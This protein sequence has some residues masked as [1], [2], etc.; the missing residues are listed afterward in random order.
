MLIRDSHSLTQEEERERS[1]ERQRDDNRRIVVCVV[2]ERGRERECKRE[3]CVRE[4]EGVPERGCV[5]WVWCVVVG[6]AR[7]A[8]ESVCERAGE[9]V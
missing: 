5:L 6:C 8:C 2:C 1:E 7:D 4:G 9:R 3:C